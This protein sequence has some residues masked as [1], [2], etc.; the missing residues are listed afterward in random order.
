VPGHPA[1]GEPP[2]AGVEPPEW[3]LSRFQ[4]ETFD[5]GEVL[6]ENT[7]LQTGADGTHPLLA[8]VHE[9]LVRG[10]WNRSKFAPRNRATAIVAGDRRW[11]GADAFRFGE[12][13]FRYLALTPTTASIVPMHV[14][15]DQAPRDVL[16]DALRSVSLDWCTTASVLTLGGESLERRAMLL[17]FDM[18]RLHPRPELEVRQRDIADLLGVARQ[19]MQPVLKKLEQ[20]GL[21]T[22]GYSEIVIGDAGRLFQELRRPQGGGKLPAAPAPRNS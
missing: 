9:G 18:S 15:R 14:L 17:L 13:H 3:L 7:F 12:N 4:P 20:R 16:V 21:V 8:Y 1:G 5:R 19:T 2:P 22:L 11:I 6:I 10:V